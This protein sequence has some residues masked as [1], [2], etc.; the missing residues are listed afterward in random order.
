MQLNSRVPQC[1][2]MF[3]HNGCFSGPLVLELSSLLSYVCR[4]S[5]LLWRKVV[6]IFLPSTSL[7]RAGTFLSTLSRQNFRS[8]TFKKYW[9]FISKFYFN[10][11]YTFNFQHSCL[12]YHIFIGY[13]P[14]PLCQCSVLLFIH[15]PI[16]AFV[17]LL[18]ICLFGSTCVLAFSL[19]I[20]MFS[21]ILLACNLFYF[22]NF[23][24][25]C[26]ILSKITFKFRN[27]LNQRVY[28]IFMLF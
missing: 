21:C 6:A 14:V 20:C 3:L 17:L 13:N 8:V 18:P 7:F 4:F 15:L 9:Q 25:S 10:L 23:F 26:P 1:L 11:T 5:R 27:S 16:R 28:K 19:L 12:M 24:K 22:F 2:S